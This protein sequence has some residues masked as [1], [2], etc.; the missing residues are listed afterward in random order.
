MTQE[1]IIGDHTRITS[2]VMTEGM[3]GLIPRDPITQ[4]VGYCSV[5]PPA[6]I[7]VYSYDE[8]VDRIADQERTKSRLSD[9]LLR[10]DAGRPIPSTDQNGQGYCWMYGAIGALQAAR[11]KAGLPYKQLSGHAAACKI[12]G[13]RDEGGWGA[14]ALEWILKNGCPDVEHWPEKS[15][16][17]SHDNAATWENAKLYRPEDVACDLTAPNYNRDLSYGQQ[18]TMLIDLNPTIDDYDFWGHCTF[19]CD[20]V[21]GATKRTETRAESGKLMSLGEFDIAWGMNDPV[22]KGL[23]K[24][25]RN[26]WTDTYGNLGFFVQTGSKAVGNNSV[27]IITATA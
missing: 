1:L 18:L 11:A 10:G 3:R 8:M 21:N 9:I 7:K 20:A 16:S 4:K 26:S 6:D 23:G 27:A 25:S 19:G 5:I 13:F 24:R 15:M 17:R 12:K 2:P 14:L 22:T